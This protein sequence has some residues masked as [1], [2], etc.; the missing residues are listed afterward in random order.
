[1]QC[2]HPSPLAD[3][4]RHLKYDK[5]SEDPFVS[6]IGLIGDDSPVNPNLQIPVVQ[7]SVQKR[8][9]QIDDDGELLSVNSDTWVTR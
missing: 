2:P 5:F 7:A 3:F 9:G 4:E 6:R 1:L 8:R